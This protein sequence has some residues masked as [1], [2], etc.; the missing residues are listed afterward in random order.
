MAFIILMIGF[1]YGAFVQLLREMQRFKNNE[2]KGE[3]VLK[4]RVRKKNDYL[5]E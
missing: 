4:V 5:V 2:N 3:S 1:I